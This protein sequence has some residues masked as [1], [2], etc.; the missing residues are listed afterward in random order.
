MVPHAK[1]YSV[2]GRFRQSAVVT[3]ELTPQELSAAVGFPVS[4]A[5]G[6]QVRVSF[7][8]VTLS[9]RVSIVGGHTLVVTAGGRQVAALELSGSG[10]LPA[11][12]MSMAIRYG[13]A[14]FS[15]RLSPVPPSLLER[16][17]GY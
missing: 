11:C 4:F 5:S 3:A 15:C 12:D 1:P 16:L 17:A 2:V 14:V 7:G 9:A 6:G 13:A 10:L 8:G